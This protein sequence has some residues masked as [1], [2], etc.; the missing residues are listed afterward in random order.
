VKLSQGSI[1]DEV[2]SK[3]GLS[4]SQADGGCQLREL[5]SAIFDLP[6]RGVLSNDTLLQFFCNFSNGHNPNDLMDCTQSRH[7]NLLEGPE[8]EKFCLIVSLK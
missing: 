6:L 3:S 1:H 5:R 2:M 8:I 4:T 7:M